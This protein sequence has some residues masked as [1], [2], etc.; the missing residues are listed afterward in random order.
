[1]KPISHLVLLITCFVWSRPLLA[2]EFWIEINSTKIDERADI[3][4]DIRVGEELLGAAL[5]YLDK[6]I[7]A[8]THDTPEASR[9]VS[10][11]LGDR[12]A[13]NGIDVSKDGLH[14]LTVETYPAYVT[15]KDIS[16]FEAYLTYEG[17]FDIIEKHQERGLPAVE[18]SE[19]YVR[20]ARALVQVGPI[21]DR[22]V[23]RST[24]MPFEIVVEG[25]PY[26]IGQTSLN[27]RLLW[28]D[29]PEPDTQIA[30]FHL[31]DGGSAPGDT[32]RRV[33]RTDQNGGARFMMA[34]AGEYLLNAVRMEPVEGPGSVV[35]KS[36]WASLTFKLPADGR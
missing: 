15:F 7:R 5:P 28:Q 36:F 1:M 14:I 2:H 22:D 33:A 30:F 18:I 27:V 24:D 35:W 26:A 32:I 4:A 12:P 20:N 23:D 17:L 3:S 10:A 8:M 31:P 34:G 19:E 25:T 21:N 6:T 9:P 11:R 13:M 16:D 29:A